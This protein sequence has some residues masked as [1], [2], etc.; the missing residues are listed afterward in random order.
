M[1]DGRSQALADAVPALLRADKELT[2]FR[3]GV[4]NPTPA[5]PYVVVRSVIKRP[6]DDPDNSADGRSR[7]YEVDSY[8]YCVGGGAGT[9]EDAEIAATAVSARVE[10][11]LVDVRPDVAGFAP[12]AVGA[13]ELLDANPPAR[14]DEMTGVPIYEIAQIYR[15]RAN[16]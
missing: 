1:T 13:L 11:Q 15:L 14:P 6:H 4:P 3:G 10:A 5:P 16:N 12:D 8:V 9:P 7:V 2:V